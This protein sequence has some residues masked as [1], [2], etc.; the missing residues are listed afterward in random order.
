[1]FEVNENDDTNS[2]NSSTIT[3]FETTPSLNNVS[4]INSNQQHQQGIKRFSNGF[5]RNTKFVN[6]SESNNVQNTLQQTNADEIHVPGTLYT[7]EMHRLL[8]EQLPNSQS[9][10]VKTISP[11]SFHTIHTGVSASSSTSIVASVPNNSTAPQSLNS[12]PTRSRNIGEQNGA[13]TIAAAAVAANRQMQLHYQQNNV[14]GSSANNSG[15]FMNSNFNY[16]NPQNSPLILSQYIYCN[17]YTPS[18][19]CLCEYCKTG[20]YYN[21]LGYHVFFDGKTIMPT[22]FNMH[23]NCWVYHCV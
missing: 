3:S 21:Q 16:Y 6:I 23:T 1:M 11:R 13:T 7:A 15:Y 19:Y 12:S 10:S 4:H 17:L 5:N 14:G 9:N 2:F 18:S 8:S 22:F 20:I